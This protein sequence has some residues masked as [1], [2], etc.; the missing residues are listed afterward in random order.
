[1]L[2]R[3]SKIE[4]DIRNYNNDNSEDSVTL[5]DLTIVDETV[6]VTLEYASYLDFEKF[7][8]ITF[9]VGTIEA[10]IKGKY[11]LDVSLQ[12]TND[13]KD[14]IMKSEI[15]NMSNKNIIIFNKPVHVVVPRKILY[16]SE[17]AVLMSHKQIET[18]AG[19]T[20]YIIY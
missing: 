2:F 15:M 16:C 17:D 12:S 7:N 6:K 14:R 19:K 11:D 18:Q 13:S 9:F 20:Q 8:Q 5:H 10:A 1:M 4:T 3:S